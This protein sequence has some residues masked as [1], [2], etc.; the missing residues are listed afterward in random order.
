MSHDWVA[1]AS[2]F[3]RLAYGGRLLDE[4]IALMP[5]KT[6][7]LGDHLSLF[8]DPS[9]YY[10]N[11]SHLKSHLGRSE[12]YGRGGAGFPLSK[13]LNAY[14]KYRGASI[15]IVA[16]GSE[17]EILSKKD[18]AL[19]AR[20]PHL[21]LDGLAIVGSSL[22]ARQ[23]YIH[24]KF[25]DASTIDI[26]RNALIERA[27]R[28]PFEIAISTS[29][30]EVGF[31]AGVESAVVSAIDGQG[32]KPLWY[33]SRP[34]E[35]GVKKRPTL[36]ANVETLAQLALLARFGSDWYAEVGGSDDSGTRLVT[37]HHPSAGPMVIEVASGTS[38]ER[39][40]SSL[41]IARASL[42]CALVGGYFGQLVE[43]ERLARLRA[44]HFAMRDAGMSQG[45]GIVAVSANCPLVEAGEIIWYL[46]RQ[47]SGQCG[48]CYL[49]LPELAELW[50]ELAGGSVSAKLLAR[51]SQVSEQVFGRGG[52]A[53]PD[54]AV[55][56]SRTA[57]MRFKTEM[58]IHQGGSCSYVTQNPTFVQVASKAVG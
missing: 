36:V 43:P 21:V 53:M 7:S 24:L 32:G 52:C 29:D 57:L 39:I 44:S 15:V 35:R 42:S 48:P 46:S 26:M 16:N 18:R 11:L 55:V 4:S 38:Y 17:S 27:G 40:V 47:S 25:D 1:R 12:I 9:G 50:K 10:D 56:V 54:G 22:R 13:K 31:V 45:A 28:D 5:S 3:P 19:M 2:S 23:G 6:N 51:I 58:I 30:P 37:A 34:I 41:G 14:E 49:G 20:H 8:G 33:L